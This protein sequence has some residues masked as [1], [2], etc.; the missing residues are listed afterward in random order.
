MWSLI[1]RRAWACGLALFAIVSVLPVWTAWYIGSW[2]ATGERASFW[3]M[4]ATVPRATQQT[5]AKTLFLDYYGPQVLQLA[6]ILVVGC[7][8][9][10]C[11]RRSGAAS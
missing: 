1:Q 5:S 9:G 4:L 10:R 3:T 11:L 2:E 6:V 8:V 7:F